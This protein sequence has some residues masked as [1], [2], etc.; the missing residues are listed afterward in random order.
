MFL[1]NTLL[2]DCLKWKNCSPIYFCYP[3]I[4]LPPKKGSRELMSYLYFD[5]VLAILLAA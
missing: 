5:H 1:S 4:P 3:P 2:W